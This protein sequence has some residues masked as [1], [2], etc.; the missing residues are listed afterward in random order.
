MNDTVLVVT[1]ARTLT[2]FHRDGTQHR[3]ELPF[4]P[5]TS[6]LDAEG[7]WLVDGR[8]TL[9]RCDLDGTERHAIPLEQPLAEIRA[10]D[11][12][13]DGSMLALV[14]HRTMLYSNGVHLRWPFEHARWRTTADRTVSLSDNGHMLA[15]QFDHEPEDQI[16]NPFHAL[17]VY[18]T[19]GRTHERH[20]SR[21]HPIEFAFAPNGRWLASRESQHVAELRVSTVGG[22]TVFRR[23]I[24]GLR[25]F[26]FSPDS[27][28]LIVAHEAL[29]VVDLDLQRIGHIDVPEAFTTLVANERDVVAIHPELGAWW[30]RRADLSYESFT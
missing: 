4:A 27:L 10:A 5:I 20:V 26:A 1:G 6:K 2:R 11:V 16:E 7:M 25:S 18:G 24:P 15:V 8:G 30:F 14:A 21:D 17:F 12:T 22:A 3:I 23:A 29:Y 19:D 9:Y 13:P 28:L